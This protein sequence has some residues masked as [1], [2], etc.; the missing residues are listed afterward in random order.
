MA[1][2]LR[3]KLISKGIGAWVFQLEI[4]KGG[5][6]ISAVK[7]GIID[8]DHFISYVSLASLGSLWVQK[9][10]TDIL[11][12]RDR[13][14][15]TIFINSNEPALLEYFN[16]WPGERGS[17]RN[18][19]KEKLI[20]ESAKSVGRAADWKWKDRCSDFLSQLD[21]YLSKIKRVT[22]YPGINTGV[23]TN[24]KI[25]LEKFR[26]FPGRIKKDAQ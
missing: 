18:K 23:W 19:N 2:E 5:K 16:N 24:K 22:A 4:K 3:N 20:K 10:L 26:F 7:R 6:I 1:F 12:D 15:V 11:K 25:K 21:E 8:C 13:Q 9:E 14:C 17:E